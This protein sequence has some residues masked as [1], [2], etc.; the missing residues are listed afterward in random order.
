MQSSQSEFKNKS[1]ANSF[2]DI[3]TKEGINGLYRVSKVI[4]LIKYI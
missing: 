1:M 4:N 3:Y 2:I